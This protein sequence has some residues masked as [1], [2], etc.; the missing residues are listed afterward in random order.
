MDNQRLNLSLKLQLYASNI[1]ETQKAE[2]I[3]ESQLETY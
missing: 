2:K 1:L 3:Q